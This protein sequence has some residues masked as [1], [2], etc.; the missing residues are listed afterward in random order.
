MP[1][2]PG[3]FS[4]GIQNTTLGI[5]KNVTTDVYLIHAA[6]GSLFPSSLGLQF[7]YITSNPTPQYA[8]KIISSRA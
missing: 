3:E 6:K 1:N 2:I 5:T 8:W 4:H 7:F